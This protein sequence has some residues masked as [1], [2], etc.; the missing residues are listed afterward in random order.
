MDLYVETKVKIYKTI[1][2]P[3]N[4]TTLYNHKYLGNGVHNPGLVEDLRN[5]KILAYEVKKLTT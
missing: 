2:K 1:T 5:R 3:E 4:D